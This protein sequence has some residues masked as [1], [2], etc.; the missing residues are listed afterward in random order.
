MQSRA[1]RCTRAV[2]HIH[3]RSYIIDSLKSQIDVSTRKRCRQG[4]GKDF[5]HICFCGQLYRH[6]DTCHSNRQKDI[7]GLGLHC[8]LVL[9]GSQTSG[10]GSTGRCRQ[11]ES[12]KLKEAVMWEKLWLVTVRDV[13]MSCGVYLSAE[14][15]NNE[16]PGLNW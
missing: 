8:D 10:K 9:I 15:D 11:A 3:T 1:I 13:W 7:D 2:N 14:M 5:C 4:R 6:T 12:K 16:P